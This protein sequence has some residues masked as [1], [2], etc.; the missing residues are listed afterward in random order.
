MGLSLRARSYAVPASY[1]SVGIEQQAQCSDGTWEV[2]G[3]GTG[4]YYRSNDGWYL[5]TNWHVV[6]GRNPNNPR[7][8]LPGYRATPQR[9]R[10][11]VVSNDQPGEQRYPEIV[12][13]LFNEGKPAWLEHSSP[14]LVDLAAIPIPVPKDYIARCLQD[15]CKPTHSFLEPGFDVIVV[16]FPFPPKP[17]MLPVWK[18][19]SVASEP[20]HAPDGKRQ[21]YLDTP[22]RPGMSGS[23]VYVTQ[24]GLRGL[25]DPA[26]SNALDAL[27]TISDRTL[28][29]ARSI[30]VEFAG[31]YAGT[32]GD[33]DLE[34]LN[35][36]RMIPGQFL[37]E[38][39]EQG[40]GKPGAHHL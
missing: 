11:F 28:E 15:V 3:N 5:V 16:G 40:F 1:C 4:F 9:L 17:M 36:G 21:I 22:G 31:V 27:S 7:E 39:L 12:L 8:L 19:A 20:S 13:E 33:R 30:Y 10:Y 38:M 2:V 23:P 18:K 14:E 26:A 37:E 35:L 29:E 32:Y 6:T 34:R 25:P 24:P